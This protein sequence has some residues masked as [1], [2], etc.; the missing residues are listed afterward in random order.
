M[1][2]AD[3]SVQ[4]AARE[5]ADSGQRIADLFK[6]ISAVSLFAGL[7]TLL[8]F[9]AAFRALRACRSLNE[10]MAEA[11]ERG[12]Q[13]AGERM[14]RARGDMPD[15][16]E[17]RIR[18]ALAQWQD[19][20]GSRQ[21][22]TIRDVVRAS[23]ENASRELRAVQD[24]VRH[25]VQEFRSSRGEGDLCPAPAAYSR[26]DQEELTADHDRQLRRAQ[27]ELDRVVAETQR[28]RTALDERA[29]EQERLQADAAASARQVERLTADLQRRDGAEQRRE[30]T[31]SQRQ[32][33]LE[34]RARE[35]ED[36]AARLEQSRRE[37]QD[38]QQQV[39]EAD[40]QARE[41]EQQAREQAQQA[42]REQQRARE[43]QAEAL[44][45]QTHARQICDGSWPAVFRSGPLANWRERIEAHL[46]DPGSAAPLLFAAMFKYHTLNRRDD[47]KEL[48][49]ALQ[50]VSRFA[51]QFWAEGG[52]DDDDQG[53]TAENWARAFEAE[54]NGKYFIRVAKVGE[55][56]DQTWMNYKPD[57]KPVSQVLSWCVLNDKSV[58]MCRAT[59]I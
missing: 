2:N 50:E 44:R 53:Q 58:A 42:E 36:Q 18:T 10:A 33:D 49:E 41:R 35:L 19:G 54:L 9:V 38:A 57:R 25:A 27:D 20:A 17:Q 46:T 7:C 59:V 45:L 55:P 56:K 16:L 5:L 39:A 3:R 28:L 13:Q 23:F 52:L 1:R 24:E 12:L 32:A 30:A 47:A 31:W 40:R 37:L 48:P 22:A 15:D 11:I 6:Q 34:R 21:E 8:A 4:T 14:A 51:Y 43:S 29:A 26:R